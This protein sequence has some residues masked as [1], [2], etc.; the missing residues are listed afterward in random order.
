LQAVGPILG[1]GSATADYDN[2]GDLDIAVGSIGGALVLLENVGEG[3]NWLQVELE[4]FHPGA[5]IT[6][7]LPDGRELHRDVRAGSSYLSS[8]DPRSHF[9]LGE[10][11]EVS[12]LVV[13][14]PGGGESRIEDVDANQLLVV[15]ARS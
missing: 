5:V 11:A 6:A 9:G 14:W 15:E 2:D 7:V 13:R 8:E 10:A 1:R 3:G 12:E 4:G